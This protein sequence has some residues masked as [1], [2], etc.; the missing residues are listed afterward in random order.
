VSDPEP[1]AGTGSGRVRHFG[2]RL[3]IGDRATFSKTITDADLVL[4]AGVTGDVHPVHLDEDYARRAGLRG[5]VVHGALL[6]AFMSA[7]DSILFARTELAAVSRGFDRVRFIKPVYV[8]DTI[9]TTYGVVDIDEGL[10][11]SDG[12]CRCV[13]QNGELVAVARHLAQIMNAS[14][15]RSPG[16][17]A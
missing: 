7:V 1:T 11:R 10:R 3:A 9:T 6:V 14:G 2:G 4:F 15:G 5:R 12:E 8:G 13:N 17:G 16:A